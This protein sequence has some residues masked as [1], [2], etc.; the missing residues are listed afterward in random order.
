M[1]REQTDR[2]LYLERGIGYERYATDLPGPY[3]Q[4]R[5]TMAGYVLRADRYCL[6]GVVN[7]YL[8]DDPD[9][10][11]FALPVVVLTLADLPRLFLTDNPSLGH[12]HEM[13]GAYQI[14]CIS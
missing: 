8:R 1:T 4:S 14:A 2:A 12:T 3:T 5:G 13:E 7:H 10:H 11:Y 9:Q 6:Q